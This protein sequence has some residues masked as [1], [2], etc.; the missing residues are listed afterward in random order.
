MLFIN[1]NLPRIVERKEFTFVAHDVE[2]FVDG[3]LEPYNLSLSVKQMD[4][5]DTEEIIVV[6][7]NYLLLGRNLFWITR[8]GSLIKDLHGIC[9]LEGDEDGESRKGRGH[10]GEGRAELHRERS[11]VRRQG[12]LKSEEYRVMSRS[13]DF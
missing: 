7:A 11:L 10:D 5:V 1:W 8:S 6:L 2:L 4:A 13:C 3:V 12:L 9:A